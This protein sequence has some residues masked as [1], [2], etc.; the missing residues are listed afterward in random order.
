MAQ[1]EKAAHKGYFLNLQL[2]LLLHQALGIFDAQIRNPVAEGLMVNT[3]DVF[4]QISAVG[5]Y[6]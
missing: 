5:T 6:P 3:V 2:G 1:R 4:G